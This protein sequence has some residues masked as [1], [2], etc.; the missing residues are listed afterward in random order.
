[1]VLRMHD[2]VNRGG[3]PNATDAHVGSQYGRK[4]DRFVADTETV[5][6]K[7][8]D[9]RVRQ[10]EGLQ[11]L[12]LGRVEPEGQVRRGF[13]AG[14]KGE[15]AQGRLLKSAFSSRETLS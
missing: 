8:P 3:L 11:C 7:A 1:M 12:A 9:L 4:I 10:E 14:G 5:A 2:S 6:P 15:L 13:E